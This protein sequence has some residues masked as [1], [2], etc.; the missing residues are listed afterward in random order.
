[1]SSDL[2][3]TVDIKLSRSDENW[4]KIIVA[5]DERERSM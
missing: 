1:M 4:T 2:R 5:N 3:W